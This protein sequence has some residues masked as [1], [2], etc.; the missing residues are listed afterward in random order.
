MSRPQRR[1]RSAHSRGGE[2]VVGVAALV[3]GVVSLVLAVLVL[4]FPIAGLLGIIAA[5]LGIGGIRRATKGEAD[6]RG[7]AIASLVTGLLGLAIAVFFT[8]NIGAFFT[9]HQNDFRK[10]GTCMTSPDTKAQTKACGRELTDQL[11]N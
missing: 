1:R 11:D 8:V 9:E 5:G 6:N 3:V 10:F 2:T 7:Q 4:Y